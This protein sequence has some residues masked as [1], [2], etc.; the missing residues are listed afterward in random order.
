ML[1]FKIG[2]KILELEDESVQE[3]KEAEESMSEETFKFVE[4]DDIDKY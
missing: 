1:K 2:E 4:V 3:E